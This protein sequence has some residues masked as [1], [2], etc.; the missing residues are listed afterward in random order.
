MPLLRLV[1]DERFHSRDGGSGHDTLCRHH[2]T[3]N[4]DIPFFCKNEDG[5]HHPIGAGAKGEAD[6]VGDVKVDGVASFGWGEEFNVLF[7]VVGGDG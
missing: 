5:P 2:R 7:R 4:V 3:K 6:G 1:C